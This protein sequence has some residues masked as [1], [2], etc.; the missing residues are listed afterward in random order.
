MKSGVVFQ[1]E[2]PHREPVRVRGFEF[3]DERGVR[4]CAVVGS[5]RG[6]EV[7]QTFVCARLVAL[8]ANL[9]HDG[10]LK[11]GKSVL[12]IPCV[13]PF[14]MNV[15]RRF[16]PM[17]RADINRSFPGDE[18]GTTTERI[19]AALLR[20]ARTFTYGIQLCSFNQRGDFLPHVRIARQGP[21]SE[22]SAELARDFGLPYVLLRTPSA[23]DMTT[24]N[25]VWQQNDTHAFSLYSQATDRIDKGS[26][27]MVVDAV[28]RFL[29]ARDVLALPAGGEV[30]YGTT[31]ILMGEDALVDVRTR[32]A[33]GFLITLVRVGEHVRK[34]QKL[35]QV[36]D[37]FDTHV[38][39][40]LQAPVDGRVLFMRTD[41]LV[42]QHMVVLRIAPTGG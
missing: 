4:S 14:S 19:A 41:S 25:Y 27:Q 24:L 5:L 11:A 7:Q 1:M 31:S 15:Q 16:W 42:Q 6:N 35:A 39:E 17:D 28:L 33:A 32:R 10:M 23:F 22:R 12:V 20:V 29:V 30:A 3:G 2:V 37:A 8:L 38:L 34:G 18:D 40:T 26:A 21:I 36:L 9:E 13:N